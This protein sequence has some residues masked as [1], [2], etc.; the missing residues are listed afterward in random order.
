MRDHLSLFVNGQPIRVEGDDVFLTLSDFL[1]KRLRLT[2]TKVVCAEGDCGSCSAF[3]GRVRD[4][5]IH[6]APVTSCI[7]LMLQLDGTHVVTIEGLKNGDELNAI[8]QSMVAG[9][10]A[11]CGFCT[12][13]FIVSLYDLMRDGKRVSS[14]A[15]TRGLVG[16]LCRCTGYD[17][18]LK[19][20]LATDQSEIRSL[21][22]LYPPGPILNMI[23]KLEEVLVQAGPKKFYKPV[24]LAAATKFRRENPNCSVIAGATDLGV[25]YNKRLREIDIA[26]SLSGIPELRGISVASGVLRIGAGNSLTELEQITLEYLPEFGRFL[27][28]FGSPLIKNA[29]TVGGNLV[30]GSPI[31]DT[32]PPWIVLQAEIEVAGVAGSRTVPI[33]QFYSG[34]R[35]TVLGPDEL[36]MG[37]RVRLLNAD[38]D[39]KLYKVSRR[40]DLDISTFSA[41]IWM[42]R[43]AGRVAEVRLAF[44]GVG[45]MVLRMTKT[46]AALAGQPATLE[47]FERAAEIAREE[48]TP[49][50]DVRGSNAYRRTLA[51]NILLKF[52]HEV[53]SESGG[54]HGNAQMPP[55]PAPANRLSV[56]SPV[57]G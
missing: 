55:P 13:G 42:R 53:I 38:D 6:Y 33:S 32:L 25:V 1:R 36:V 10:G 22:S 28:W 12:P 9:H 34:Y 44:G 39:F 5:K 14:E 11:Q 2:G 7:Q 49:I 21:D 19:S 46:E 24:T 54:H 47:Q 51:G 17:S 31:G 30:T 45:P 52:W 23:S 43:Q 4:G 8:Q 57:A 40:K 16:N 20:A 50:T 56:P 18:I 27:A 48:V 37:V 26:L 41:A 3:I 15:I 29:G 35:T